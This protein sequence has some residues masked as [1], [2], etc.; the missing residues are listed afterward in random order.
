MIGPEFLFDCGVKS[1][2]LLGVTAVSATLLRSRP[3]AL[4]HLVWCAGIVAVLALPLARSFAPAVTI[5]AAMDLRTTIDI[6]GGAPA[7]RDTSEPVDPLPFAGWTWLGGAAVV[8]ARLAAGL[9]RL[10]ILT[11]RAVPTS[12]PDSVSIPARVRVL[13]SCEVSAP[14]TWGAVRPVILLPAESSD[15]P[16]DRLRVALAHELAHI[17]RFDWMWQ[18]LAQLCCALYWFNPL[19]WYAERRMCRERE[20]ACDDGV[21]ANGVLGSDYARHLVEIARSVRRDESFSVGVAMARKSNLENRVLAMLNP[22]LKRERVTAKLFAVAA[23]LC[24]AVLIPLAG[25]RATAQGTG[26]A[27]N[28]SV[29]DASHA[30][31]TGASVYMKNLSGRNT[32]ITR[33]NRAG[34]YAFSAL[35]EGRYQMEVKARGF[36]VYRVDVAVSSGMSAVQNVVLNVGKGSETMDIVGKS[37][38]P[39]PAESSPARVNAGGEVQAMKLVHMVRPLYPDHL[40]A[41]GI[42]GS[43]LL[44][45][46]VGTDGK[47]LSLETQNIQVHEELVKAAKEAVS[48]W[49]YEP[50]QLNGEPVEVIVSVELNF[51]LQ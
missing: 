14:V 50:T 19:S 42:E 38:N 7:Q 30:A 29:L 3:A 23:V 2:T 39:K 17:R 6:F 31:V 37:P 51:R 40:K 24:A 47:V 5:P 41:Q 18:F 43:V 1:A 33:T 28:G 12:L 25:L 36:E 27:V 44:K 16:Q 20:L 49:R 46:V 8:G 22:A 11:R 34:E 21:L 4:R 15:W 10:S 48:Q 13:S 45:A 26:G 32:E 9:A 35:P